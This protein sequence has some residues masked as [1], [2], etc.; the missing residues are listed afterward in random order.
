MLCAISNYCDAHRLSVDPVYYM[1][2]IPVLNY[3]I[4]I[5]AARPPLYERDHTQHLP[6]KY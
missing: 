1:R 2:G 3:Y 6:V 4:L 5:R